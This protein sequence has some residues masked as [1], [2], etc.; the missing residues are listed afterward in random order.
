MPKDKFNYSKKIFT[1]FLTGF[2]I[3]LIIV[4]VMKSK[5]KSVKANGSAEN[6]IKSG[7]MNVTESR[8]IFL[9]MNVTKTARPKESSG[10][11]SVHSS[12]SGASHGGRGGS[13]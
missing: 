9:Y 6:Y 3:A 13:F 10:G 12:S 4:L 11:S 5:L 7:S 8:D 1:S 2:I